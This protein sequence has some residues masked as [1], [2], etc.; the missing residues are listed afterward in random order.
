MKRSNWDC[1]NMALILW[2]GILAVSLAALIKSSDFFTTASEKIGLALKIPAFIIGVTIVSIGTSL[3]ELL[4]S[5]VAVVY[6]NS[7]IV[8]G[9]VV[10][11]NITNIFLGLGLLPLI[12]GFF[13]VDKNI[14]SVDL[15][16]LL[17][18][19]FFLVI[20]CYDGSFNQ[21]EALFGLVGFIIYIRYAMK[22]HREY[23]K[24]MEEEKIASPKLNPL[25][26]L[27]LAASAAALYFSA[28]YTVIAI[29]R[30]AEI[31]E[32]GTEVITASAVAMGTSL[33]EII[34]SIV[35]AKKGKTDIAVGTLLGSNIFNAFA[36]MGISGLIGKLIIPE[37]MIHFGLP[38]LVL[39]TLLYFFILM[40]QEITKYEGALLILFY[41]LF[42][43]KLFHLF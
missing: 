40:D 3:P 6:K 41:G 14:V 28:K 35:A 23:R 7:E 25:H 13:K 42:L 11:S 10:G 30:L 16:I 29:I 37:M 24:K 39:A 26:F 21:I 8:I 36:I 19:T 2:L 34:T 4:T 43:G 12:I 38:M 1:E 27:I 5:V 20:T 9:D 22:E 31:A 15:P 32:I 33:P 17:G 18:T